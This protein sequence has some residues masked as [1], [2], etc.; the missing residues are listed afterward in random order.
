MCL[1]SCLLEC[2]A[3]PV[4]TVATVGLPA[5]AAAVAAFG[6]CVVSLTACCAVMSSLTLR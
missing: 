2:F 3:E 1:M 5:V 6:T 4:L